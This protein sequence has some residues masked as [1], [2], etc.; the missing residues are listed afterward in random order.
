MD[1]K[2]DLNYIH[3]KYHPKTI[4]KKHTF[5]TNTLN[6]CILSKFDQKVNL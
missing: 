3:V 4:K 5:C 6:N 1:K 2:I